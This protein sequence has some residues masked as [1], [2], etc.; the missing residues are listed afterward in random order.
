MR[1]YLFN[2]INIL[3]SNADAKILSLHR[4]CRDESIGTQAQAFFGQY[5]RELLPYKTTISDEWVL[6]SWMIIYQSLDHL[7]QAAMRPRGGLIKTFN[8]YLDSPR[9][10]RSGGVPSVNEVEDEERQARLNDD[11]SARILLVTSLG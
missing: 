7:A 1:Q 11:D 9:D 3:S 5:H 10:R 8:H 6:N 4:W 2:D